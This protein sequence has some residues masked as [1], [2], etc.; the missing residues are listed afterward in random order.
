VD[1]AESH[2]PDARRMNSELPMQLA[3][4]AY[5]KN[6]RLIH[7][8]T[9]YVHSGEGNTPWLETSLTSPLSAYGI[10]KR[11]GDD[12]IISSG[13]DYLIFRTSWVYSARGDNFMKTILRLAKCKDE[14][15]I[16]GDQIGAPTPAHLISQITALAIYNGLSSGLYNLSTKGKTSWFEFALKI[17]E[18]A[19]RA[20]EKLKIR[21]SD[22][23][24]VDSKDYPAVAARPLNSL[25][26]TSKLEK[27][28]NI[29]LPTWESQLD[30]ILTE[31]LEGK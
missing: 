30:L 3:S 10:T 20:G 5:S 23:K 2:V 8:S 15:R 29:Q 1:E 27:A 14:L 25:L 17:F 21:M 4:F 26:D 7:Y 19:E 22:I 12:A 18:L 16:V 6:I 13:V 24:T 9:D 31:Y 28:L 11:D